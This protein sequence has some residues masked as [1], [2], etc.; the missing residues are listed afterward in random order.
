MY[1]G[2]LAEVA[3]VRRDLTVCL[4]GVPRADDVILAASEL[5]ANCVLHARSRMFIVRCEIFPGAYVRVEAQDAGADWQERP[6]GDRPHGT[7]LIQ[8][9]AGEWGTER[10]TGGDRVTWARLEW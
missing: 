9:L 10:S 7:D 1:R 2:E 4:R 8:A 5:A 3:R 6:P